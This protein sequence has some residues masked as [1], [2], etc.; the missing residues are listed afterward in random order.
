[1]NKEFNFEESLKELEKNVELLEKGDLP[2][3]E[4]IKLF[5]KGITISK[6]CSKYLEEAKQKISNL[7]DIENGES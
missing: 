4:A 3:D 2:L 7:T 1:M 5:E 6:D